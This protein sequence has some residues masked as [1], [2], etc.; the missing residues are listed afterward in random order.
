SSAKEITQLIKNSVQKAEGGHTLSEEGAVVL[1]DILTKSVQV[2][3][4]VNDI[5]TSS[6]AQNRKVETMKE[7]VENI[8]SASHQQA[9]ATQQVSSAVVEMD[10]VT[11]ANSASAEESASASEE[12]NAQAETLKGLV[13]D[14]STHFAVKLQHN[15][16]QRTTKMTPATSPKRLLPEESVHHYTPKQPPR[17]LAGKVIKPSQAIPMRDDFKDF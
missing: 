5:S 16:S 17:P 13:E 11:Q 9:N 4:L 1:K 6:E 3:E 15:Q 14:L 7:M 10:T 12:L 2:A 8:K